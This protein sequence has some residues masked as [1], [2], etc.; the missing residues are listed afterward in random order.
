MT[1]H[2]NC[3]PNYPEKV[4]GEAPQQLQL[5]DLGDGEWVKQCVD[6]G[7]VIESNVKEEEP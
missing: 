1:H 2:P 7:A 6:C 5:I 3:N 4:E